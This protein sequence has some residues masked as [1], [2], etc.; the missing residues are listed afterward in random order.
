MR[1]RICRECGWEY[2]VSRR[3]RNEKHYICRFAGIKKRRSGGQT[4]K[5]ALEN[6]PITS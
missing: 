1:Y 4:P 2:N 3:A 6:E 5:G